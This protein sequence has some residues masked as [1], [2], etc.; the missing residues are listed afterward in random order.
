M[1]LSEKQRL[2]AK[3]I[4]DFLVWIYA[5]GYEVTG[6]EWERNQTQAQ[7]DAKNHTGIVHSLHILRL[8]LDLN[9]FVKGVYQTRSN[10]YSPLGEHW[11]TLHPLCRWGGDFSKPDGN[12]FSIEHEGVR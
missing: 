11:K 10:A 2:F 8:A 3:L 5:N 12:H 6:G 1:A 9:L 4:G 7:L